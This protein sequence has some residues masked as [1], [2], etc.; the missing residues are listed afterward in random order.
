MKYFRIPEN[1]I[2]VIYLGLDVDALTKNINKSGYRKIESREFIIGHIGRLT[3]QKAQ[4]TLL[5]ALKL[6]LKKYPDVMLVII[7]D[8]E[9][10][11]QLKSYIDAEDI[12]R[13]VTFK[14]YIKDVFNEM[15]NFDV[16]VLTSRF[17]GMG[18]VNL[19]AMELGVPVITSNVGGA[20]NFL[21]DGYDALITEVDNENST[22]HAIERLKSDPEFR[23]NIAANARRTVKDYS[24]ERMVRETSQFY[25]K[26]LVN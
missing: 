10:K 1:K 20:S 25:L 24:I 22:A 9:D 19:E 11:E 18:Y 3:Y 8:G 2:D 15:M 26:N 23:K 14:G 6:I 16:H 4:I 5:K 13:N 12:S 17:E 7:G 21:T